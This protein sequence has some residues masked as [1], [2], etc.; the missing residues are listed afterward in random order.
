MDSM[1]FV[2]EAYREDTGGGFE[3]DVFVL[4]DGTVLVVGEESIVLYKDVMAWEE[5]SAEG[6]VG[7]I[8][9]ENVRGYANAK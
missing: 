3:C 2:K 4:K 6:Q 1:V 8:V 9:R 7:T 5:P